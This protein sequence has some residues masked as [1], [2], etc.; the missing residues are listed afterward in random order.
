MRPVG[1]YTRLG[2]VRTLLLDSDDRFVVFG[3]GDEVQLD[4]DP[5]DLPRL[6]QGWARD[7]FFFVDGYEKDMDFY[8]ATGNSV[9]PLPFHR[10]K[11]YPYANESY[12][13]DEL[14]SNDLLN[15]DD[16]FFSTA[17]SSSFRFHYPK[18]RQEHGRPASISRRDQPL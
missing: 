3:S 8:A 17:P 1:A 13:Q 10:M 7:Y 12:P 18:R 14:H 5:A 2:D 16:R 9:A 6:P 15:Y 4:F 11:T